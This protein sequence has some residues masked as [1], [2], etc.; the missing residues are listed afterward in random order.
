[1]NRTIGLIALAG[2]GIGYLLC[3]DK[4]R[5]LT[6]QA[7]QYLQDQYRNANDAMARRGT[8][9]TIHKALDQPHPDT[10]VAQAFE[11]ALA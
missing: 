2:A 9:K 5:A 10:A 6:H 3:T 4:G 8:E 11:E 7:G 1:M